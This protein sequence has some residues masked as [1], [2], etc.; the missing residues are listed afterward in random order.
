M[1]VAVQE[2]EYVLAAGTGT[3]GVPSILHLSREL[4]GAY[5]LGEE[6]AWV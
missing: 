1:R 6:S 5:R 2:V 3:R 4:A